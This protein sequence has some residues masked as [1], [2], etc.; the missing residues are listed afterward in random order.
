MAITQKDIEKARKNCGNC[1]GGGL[2]RPRFRAGDVVKLLNQDENG[3]IVTIE[4][5]GFPHYFKV[6]G[7]PGEYCETC[8]SRPVSRGRPEGWHVLARHKWVSG[9]VITEQCNAAS[10]CKR[11]TATIRGFRNWRLWEGDYGAAQAKVKE[12][13]STVR[14]IVERVDADDEAVFQETGYLVK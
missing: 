11:C 6:A 2:H 4:T 10:T 7:K 3:Q 1:K 14:K 8:F 5:E 9:A 12:I 13:I